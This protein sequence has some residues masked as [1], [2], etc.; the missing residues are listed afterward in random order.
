MFNFN[1]IR[2]KAAIKDRAEDLD[3]QYF[4]TF[5]NRLSLVDKCL[6]T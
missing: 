6:L 4:S 5:Y 2:S 3:K 1:E